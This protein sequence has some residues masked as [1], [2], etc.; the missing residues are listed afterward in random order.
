MLLINV[1]DIQKSHNNGFFLCQQCEHFRRTRLIFNINL[2]YANSRR[3]AE[4]GG[5]E[6]ELRRPTNRTAPQGR[7]EI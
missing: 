3:P 7:R 1:L 2:H 4:R 5:Q 6:Q